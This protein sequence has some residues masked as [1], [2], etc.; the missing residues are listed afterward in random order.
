VGSLGGDFDKVSQDLRGCAAEMR[1]WDQGHQL[2]IE[3][4]QRGVIATMAENKWAI[5]RS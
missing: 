5:A 1:E 3:L 2:G 4:A